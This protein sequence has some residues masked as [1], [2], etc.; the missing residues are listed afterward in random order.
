REGI[1]GGNEE[2]GR[3]RVIL[4]GRIALG[5]MS[6]ADWAVATM[7]LPQKGHERLVVCSGT[8]TTAAH[9]WHLTA[10]S[11]TVGAAVA[12]WSRAARKASSLTAAAPPASSTGVSW[13]QYG[14]LRTVAPGWNSS[15]AP[16]LAQGYRRPVVSVVIA[17]SMRRAR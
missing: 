4:N 13:P 9:V 1:E 14:H 7:L 8:S 6:V 12:R 11:S 10:E 2:I 17:G 16:Q 3:S 5:L 15:L